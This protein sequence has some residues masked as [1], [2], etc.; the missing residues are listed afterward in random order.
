MNYKSWHSHISAIIGTASNLLHSKYEAGQKE[1][2]GE[3][4]K[5]PIHQMLLEEQLDSL[6]YSITLNEQHM[7]AK[8]LSRRVFAELVAANR[9]QSWGKVAIAIRNI[10][11][12]YNLLHYGNIEG[13]RLSN[14]ENQCPKCQ[15]KPY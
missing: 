11:K 10:E 3:L 7:E 12:L 1:H 8:S 4:W 13:E 9:E 5:K 15:Q 6:I 14:G 2:G